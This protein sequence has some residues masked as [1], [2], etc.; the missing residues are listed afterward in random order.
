[1]APGYANHVAAANLLSEI[2]SRILT[3]LTHIKKKYGINNDYGDSTDMD[4][5]DG[6]SPGASVNASTTASA[7][8]SAVALSNMSAGASASAGTSTIAGNGLKVGIMQ[9][10]LQNYNPE[11]IEENDPRYSKDTS[12]TINKGQTLRICLRHRDNP[13]KLHSINELM[14]VVLHEISH[15]GNVG[16]GHKVDFWQTFKFVLEEAVKLGVYK[17]V[18]YSVHG[19][20]YCGLSVKYNPLYDTALSQ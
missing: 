5:A 4:P 15:M 10:I 8:A 11:V 13:H 6:A 2:N 16:W 19:I 3:F 20:N 14:F 7:N 9:R 17:P 12:Y 18:D 1:V